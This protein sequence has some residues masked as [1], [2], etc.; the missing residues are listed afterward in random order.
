MAA[1]RLTL[2]ILRRNLW[3]VLPKI[4][5]RF[6]YAIG[7]KPVTVQLSMTN[8]DKI[9]DIPYNAYLSGSQLHFNNPDQTRP[10]GGAPL[11]DFLDT[12]QISLIAK[13]GTETQ[14]KAA[15]SP[16]MRGRQY[17]FQTTAA[18]QQSNPPQLRVHVMDTFDRDVEFELKDVKLRD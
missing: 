5:A 17:M 8:W 10:N 7:T 2:R 4:G 15:S 16:G 3:F 6:R 13:D 18:F 14:V 1:A 9:P 11:E 12:E